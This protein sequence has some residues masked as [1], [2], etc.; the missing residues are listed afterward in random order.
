MT[1][2]QVFEIGGAE[3]AAL[4]PDLKCDACG[5][6]LSAARDETWAK[7][8]CGYFCGQCIEAGRHL[9]HPSACRLQ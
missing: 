9:T 3:L 7:V 1:T 4:Y 5:R 2:P 6:S 8:G